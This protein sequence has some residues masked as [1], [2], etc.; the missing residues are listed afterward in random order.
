MHVQIKRPEYQ[1]YLTQLLMDK[2]RV[3]RKSWGQEL[4]LRSLRIRFFI[5]SV[6]LFFLRHP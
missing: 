5:N 6:S 1:V 4:F 2:T 3:T